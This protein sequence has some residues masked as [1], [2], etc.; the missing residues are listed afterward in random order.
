MEGTARTRNELVEAEVQA[1]A[2]LAERHIPRPGRHFGQSPQFQSPSSSL[3]TSP[4]GLHV[5]ERGVSLLLWYWASTS[6]VLDENR[7]AFVLI[8]MAVT[9]ETPH[10]L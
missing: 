8:P 6:G 5:P 2:E 10:A 4:H 7:D 9:H 1:V 3:L